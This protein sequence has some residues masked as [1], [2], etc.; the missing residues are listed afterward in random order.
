MNMKEIKLHSGELTIV[1][2]STYE[3]AKDINWYA[4]NRGRHTHVTRREGGKTLYL[5][6]LVIGAKPG[7]IVDHIN[8][9]GL[10]NRLENLRIASKAQNANNT[11]YSH[12]T[13]GYKGV[14]IRKGRNKKFRA[15]IVF[16]EKQVYIGSYYTAIEAAE[17]YDEAAIKYYGK[18]TYLNFE[19]K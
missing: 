14:T 11:R 18:D 1:D 9:D 8:R 5:H 16:N 3:W 4:I 2:E 12:N 10:D 6:R 15:T 19:E 17:A 13:S 7:E